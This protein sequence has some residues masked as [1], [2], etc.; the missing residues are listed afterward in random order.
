MFLVHWMVSILPN[1]QSNLK[2]DNLPE[3]MLPAPDFTIVANSTCLVRN[4]WAV[5]LKVE[6]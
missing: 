5:I 2:W 4:F 1:R 3:M 6:E